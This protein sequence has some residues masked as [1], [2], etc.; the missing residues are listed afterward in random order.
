MFKTPACCDKRLA[1][2]AWVVASSHLPCQ[3]PQWPTVH[4]TLCR[5]QCFQRMVRFACADTS[6]SIN[7]SMLGGSVMTVC[8]VTEM[9][10]ELGRRICCLTRVGGANVGYDTPP[11]LPGDWVPRSRS[12]QVCKVCVILPSLRVRCLIIS[13]GMP[14]QTLQLL[15]EEAITNGHQECCKKIGSSTSDVQKMKRKGFWKEN[16]LPV[17]QS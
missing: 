8:K 13:C 10:V 3:K 4:S 11:V 1:H 12:C 7:E 14:C 5:F 15:R 16:H 17:R 9:H 2:W 6:Q